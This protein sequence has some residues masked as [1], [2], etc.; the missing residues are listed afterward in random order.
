MEEPKDVIWKNT[1]YFQEHLD[2]LE[3]I[4]ENHSAANRTIL[5]SVMRNDKQNQ[6]KNTIDSNLIWI[7]FGL[8]CFFFSYLFVGL[9][10]VITFML[11]TGIFAYGA[12]GGVLSAIQRTRK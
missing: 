7:C 10:S 1:G 3:K 5:S 6:I 8:F 4:N 9:L 11:G 2:F 12:I